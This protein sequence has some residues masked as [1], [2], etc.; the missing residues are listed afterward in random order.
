[1]TQVLDPT[2]LIHENPY[3]STGTWHSRRKRYQKAKITPKQHHLAP[4]L[5]ACWE[6]TK[7]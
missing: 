1:M 4:E 5:N 3:L 6:K 2:N 7:M